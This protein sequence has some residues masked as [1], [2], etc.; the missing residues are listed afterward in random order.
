M[1]MDY[2]VLTIRRCVRDK[3]N[4]TFPLADLGGLYCEPAL[5]IIDA[6]NATYET[7][8]TVHI[9][10]TDPVTLIDVPIIDGVV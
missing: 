1:W 6:I 4:C 8:E 2:T 5:P 9:P 3:L 10:H 7:H